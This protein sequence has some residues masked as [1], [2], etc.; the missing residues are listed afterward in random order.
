MPRTVGSGVHRPCRIGK[1]I[2]QQRAAVKHRHC[3]YRTGKKT[4]QQAPA[5]KRRYKNHQIQQHGTV[6]QRQHQIARQH[7]G[8]QHRNRHQND[9]GKQRGG[10]G[11]ARNGIHC[12]HK[13]QLAV[14]DFSCRHR[15]QHRRSRAAEDPQQT[16]QSKQTARQHQRKGDRIVDGKPGNKPHDDPGDQSPQA[17]LHQKVSASGLLQRKTPVTQSGDLADNKIHQPCQRGGAHGKALRVGKVCGTRQSGNRR[18]KYIGKND[19]QYDHQQCRSQSVPHFT[20][21]LLYQHAGKSRLPQA[22]QVHVQY[23]GHTG[24]Q[25]QQVQQHGTRQ[26]PVQNIAVQ[27]HFGSRLPGQVLGAGG[28]RIVIHHGAHQRGQPS[29]QRVDQQLNSNRAAQH[30]QCALSGALKAGVGHQPH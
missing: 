17:R 8:E 1:E 14:L 19:L 2:G 6:T 25:H 21:Q 7:R 13:R 24:R 15:L 30:S 26:H 22:P 5:G 27:G 23:T 18:G 16:G 10:I 12:D 3:A 9:R 29:A 20:G 11:S 4:A 28:K